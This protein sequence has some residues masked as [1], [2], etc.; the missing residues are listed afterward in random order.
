[1]RLK[2]SLASENGPLSVPVQY[3]SLIHG[4]VYHNMDK[5]LSKWLH[6]GGHA[7]GERRFKL[8]TF[9]RLFGKRKVRDGRV[10]FDGPAR[11]YLS[12]ADAEV[13]G[14]LAEH[15]LKKPHVRLGSVRCRVEEVAVEPEPEVNG[16]AIKVKT[17]APITAYSTLTTPD[18]KKKTYFYSPQEK[19]WSEALVANIKRKAK[20]LGWEAD[21]DKDLEGAWMRPRRVKTS[22]QKVLNFKGTVIKGWTGLY[23][24]NLPEPYFRLAYDTGFGSKNSAG[25]GMV[26]VVG[27]RGGKSC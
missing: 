14:S 26:G 15:L 13:L 21:V 12:S 2:V 20:S 17:L 18:G 23:E 4:F 3:N 22:D 5:A 24:T 7:Y 8:F 19:E 6:E 10:F 16:G 11:F 27:G 9:S 1:M 25:F